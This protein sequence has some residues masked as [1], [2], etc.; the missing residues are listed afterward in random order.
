DGIV[1]DPLKAE[2]AL[3]GGKL[4]PEKLHSLAAV[5]KDIQAKALHDIRKSAKLQ[6]AVTPHADRCTSCSAML[7]RGFCVECFAGKCTAHPCRS[8]GGSGRVSGGIAGE[9][10]CGACKGTGRGE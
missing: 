10:D 2:A 9:V 7:V 1:P 4:S 3:Y 8:C 6:A 5:A